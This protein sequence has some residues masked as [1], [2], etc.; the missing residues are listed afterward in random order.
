M[1]AKCKSTIILMII[2]M[3]NISEGGDYPILNGLFL[4][5]TY[6]PSGPFDS[7]AQPCLPGDDAG[8]YLPFQGLTACRTNSLQNSAINVNTHTMH[9]T[10]GG[11]P[12]NFCRSGIDWRDDRRE[13]A[14]SMSWT[15]LIDFLKTGQD[16][17]NGNSASPPPPHTHTHTSTSMRAIDK[18]SMKQ[19]VAM[20]G[21]GSGHTIHAANIQVT[22]NEIA[23]QHYACAQLVFSHMALCS[24]YCLRT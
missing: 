18:N 2:I 23:T 7:R 16:W 6:K 21:V 4:C 3:V 12:Q 17:Q 8:Y 5:A 14:S 20:Q 22:M 13:I 24:C 11:Y 9:P 19:I 10:R 15:C 1:V